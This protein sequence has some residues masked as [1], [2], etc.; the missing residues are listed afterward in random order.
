MLGQNYP[1]PFNPITTIA[2]TLPQTE[3]VQLI[4]FDVLGREV[5]T[6]VEGVQQDAGRYEVAFDASH[7]A[8]GLYLYRI[9]AGS[10]VQVKRMV[11]LK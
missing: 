11:L 7:L 5:L 9:K 4:V 6:L 1:N 2:Y 10:F 8:S 3:R